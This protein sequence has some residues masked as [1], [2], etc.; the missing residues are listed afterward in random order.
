MFWF[1]ALFQ[2]YIVPSRCHFVPSLPF[3][4]RIQLSCRKSDF[5]APTYN[6]PA[7]SGLWLSR[8]AYYWLDTFAEFR[9]KTEE[10]C[11]GCKSP[12]S[13]PFIYYNKVDILISIFLILV[14]FESRSGKEGCYF[15]GFLNLKVKNYTRHWS[16]H[17]KASKHYV[18]KKICYYI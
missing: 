12:A 4:F 2:S 6:K 3:H 1:H 14:E 11:C 18:K 15:V 16:F 8:V 7:G 5:S 10:A 9:N 13:Q 17:F